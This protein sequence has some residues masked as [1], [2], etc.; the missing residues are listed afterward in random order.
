MHETHNMLRTDVNSLFERLREANTLLQEVLGGATENLGAIES[1][2]STRVAEFV[3]AMND[4]GERSNAGGF[5]VDE[6]IK[7]F[8]A[9][10]SNVLREIRLAEQFDAHGRPHGRRQPGRQEQPADQ[11]NARRQPHL[12]RRTGERAHRQDREPQRSRDRQDGAAEPS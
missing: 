3:S 2:L 1:S 12:D 4:V 6:H 7:S 9:M 11:G 10:S 5:Q 8:Q